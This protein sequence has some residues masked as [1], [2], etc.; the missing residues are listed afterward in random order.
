[1]VEVIVGFFGVSSYFKGMVCFD[2]VVGVV[3]V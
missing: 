3:L 2:N 1:M